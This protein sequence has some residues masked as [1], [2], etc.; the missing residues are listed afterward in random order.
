VSGIL[1]WKGGRGRGETASRVGSNK[2]IGITVASFSVDETTVTRGK[3]LKIRYLIDCSEDVSGEIWLGA[4]F[5]DKQ[6]KYIFNVHQDKPVSLLKGRHEYDRD[7]TIPSNV[8]PGSYRLQ[9]NVWQGV[10]GNS[11]QSIRLANGG[12]VEIVVVA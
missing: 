11:T 6:G 9:G 8:P 7:L 4:S 1:T 3:T 10:L 5:P 2:I 12:P